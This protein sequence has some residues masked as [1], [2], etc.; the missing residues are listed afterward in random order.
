MNP[1]TNSEH[2]N[3]LKSLNGS[4]FS[5]DGVDTKK[6]KKNKKRKSKNKKLKKD[7][8]PVAEEDEE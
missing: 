7:L 1:K 5:E 8:A 4:V 6:E 3:D 2:D